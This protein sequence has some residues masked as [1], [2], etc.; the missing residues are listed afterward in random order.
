MSKVNTW[1]N[2]KSTIKSPCMNCKDRTPTCHG[3][4]KCKRYSDYRKVVEDNRRSEKLRTSNR[5]GDEWG[6]L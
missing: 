2:S 6:G 5:T 1:W 4:D 3:Y